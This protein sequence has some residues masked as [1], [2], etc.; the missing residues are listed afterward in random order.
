MNYKL[1]L[2]KQG[3]GPNIIFHNII[4][5]FFKVNI[6]ERYP[7]SMASTLSPDFVIFKVR[8][9]NDEIINTKKGNGRVKLKGDTFLTYKEI[10]KVLNSYEYQYRFIYR[11][12]AI[13]KFV[14]FILGLVVSN[15]KIYWC[16][17]F[18]R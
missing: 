12:S 8:T 18:S 15:Y 7:K 5:D 10:I 1:E 6:V 17:F 16:F 4:F 9:L 3:I 14:D 13:Q 11:D 2:N